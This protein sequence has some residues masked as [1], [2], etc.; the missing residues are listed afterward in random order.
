MKKLFFILLLFSASYSFSQSMNWQQ[1]RGWKIYD[2]HDKKGM[3]TPVD[4]LKYFRSI[5]LDDD[6]IKYFL[7]GA[8]EIHHGDEPV[9]MGAIILSGVDS[10]GIF[11]KVDVSVYGGFFYDEKTRKYYQ[12]RDEVKEEWMEYLTNKGER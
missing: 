8:T 4:S 2:L 12:V 9:W 1:M 10:S 5:T 3:R 6:S 7:L 11:S